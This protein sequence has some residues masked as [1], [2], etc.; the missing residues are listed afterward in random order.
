MD[1][2]NRDV[3][4]TSYAWVGLLALALFGLPAAAIE[5]TD[6]TKETPD[7]R[8][9]I[10][11]Q[12]LT[13]ESLAEINETRY[14]RDRD[15][16][17]RRFLALTSDANAPFEVRRWATLEVMRYMLNPLGEYHEALRMGDAWLAKHPDDPMEIKIRCALA[18]IYVGRASSKKLAE[19]QER[20]IRE[21]FKPSRHERLDAVRR[22][23][24]PIFV[25]HSE[26]TYDLVRAHQE[27]ASA[28]GTL[29]TGVPDEWERSDE[30]QALDPR[31]REARM[32]R[33]RHGF[34]QEQVGHLK[35]AEGL[36]QMV[37]D[38]PK[39]TKDAQ[40]L[41]VKEGALRSIQHHAMLAEQE[42]QWVLK[43]AEGVESLVVDKAVEQ[44][45]QEATE[46]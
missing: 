31:A 9:L 5:I 17:H 37:I 41:Q 10:L 28:L 6:L 38:D 35:A 23:M 25:K 14:T 7:F 1:S 33:M 24:D 20:E 29:G 4:V 43:R 44:V 3:P 13:E 34:H 12:R 30:A 11:E 22:L 18:R 27:Y 19:L 46:E 39:V 16:R 15:E 26:P 32:L 40:L 36:V 8:L 42:A 2:M 45:W 21:P